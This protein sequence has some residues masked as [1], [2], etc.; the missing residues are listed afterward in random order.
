MSQSLQLSAE[1]MK[2]LMVAWWLKG[3]QIN[4]S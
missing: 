1:M 2:M 3:W 4:L